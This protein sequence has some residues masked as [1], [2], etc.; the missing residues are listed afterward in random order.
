MR[1]S[2]SGVLADACTLTRRFVMPRDLLVTLPRQRIERCPLLLIP[3][4]IRRVEFDQ[5]RVDAGAHLRTCSI[6][7]GRPPRVIY[8][9]GP[10]ARPL[11]D[12]RDERPEVLT[13]HLLWH[14]K[15]AA[16]PLRVALD[17]FFAAVH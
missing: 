13:E 10:V 7:C 9:H 12:A 5:G 2:Q 6:A 1:A 3:V 16:D 14:A 8:G 15:G 11:L 17:G 4:L